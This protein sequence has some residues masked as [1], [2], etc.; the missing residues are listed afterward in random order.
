ML[1]Y[2]TK[3]PAE[4]SLGEISRLLAKSGAS[5]VMHEYDDSG[6]IKSLSFKMKLDGQEI[7]F[8]LPANWSGIESIMLEERRNRNSTLRPWML[9]KDHFVNVSWR[10]IKDWIEAQLALIEANQATA[11]Q[12]FLPYAITQNGQTLAERIQ[13]NP[14]MLLGMGG[15]N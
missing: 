2:T 13:D 9:E 4:R 12:V 11:Q 8:R 7:G 10:V 6:D 5:A 3:V 1:N 15:S 14:G